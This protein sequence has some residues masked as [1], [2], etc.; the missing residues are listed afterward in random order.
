VTVGVG[1]AFEVGPAGPKRLRADKAQKKPAFSIA[2]APH[3]HA[4]ISHPFMPA[5]QA[6]V[7]EKG[8]ASAVAAIRA[9][10]RKAPPRTRPIAPMASMSHSIA[11]T[12][13]ALR[14]GA[15]KGRFFVPP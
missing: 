13:S 9:G 12:Q 7:I 11:S 10:A 6:M 4:P 3:A 1:D 8:I 5:D 15:P 2:N 14:P